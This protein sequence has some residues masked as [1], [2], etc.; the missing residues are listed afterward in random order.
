MKQD[1]CKATDNL[2]PPCL[3]ILERSNCWVSCLTLGEEEQERGTT[4]EL[5]ATL[6]AL[7]PSHKGSQLSFLSLADHSISLKRDSASCLVSL[8]G[9]LS[10]LYILSL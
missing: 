9:L 2:P 7:I 6:P 5:G 8:E 1:F 10:L 3:A 4:R